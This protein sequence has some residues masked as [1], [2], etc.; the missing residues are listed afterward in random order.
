MRDLVSVVEFATEMCAAVVAGGP[1]TSPVGQATR[2]GHAA[3]V[4]FIGGRT[5]A[6]AG[7]REEDV[8]DLAAIEGAFA[9]GCKWWEGVVAV[10]A[11][12]FEIF[13]F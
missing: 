4:A 7:W 2:K 3:E 1:G 13:D 5:G 9:V 10:E 11:M 6:G 8:A 12:F